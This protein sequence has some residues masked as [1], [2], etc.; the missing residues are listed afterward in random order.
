MISIIC[1]KL[2]YIKIYLSSYELS[3]VY[4]YK[5]LHQSQKHDTLEQC[6]KCPKKYNKYALK[7]HLERTHGALKVC[8]KCGA[9]VDF[10]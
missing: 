4:I 8:T 5:I 3:S 2:Q 9:K 1:F 7:L 10:F 6:P